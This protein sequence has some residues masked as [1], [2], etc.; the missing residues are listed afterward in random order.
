MGTRRTVNVE[1]HLQFLSSRWLK[2]GQVAGEFIGVEDIPHLG[3][4]TR[5]LSGELRA[6]IC[7]LSKIQQ[8]FAEKIIQRALDAELL[9]DPAGRPALMHPDLV[10]LHAG[11]YIAGESRTQITPGKTGGIR[12]IGCTPLNTYLFWNSLK[13]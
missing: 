2:G 11:N 4:K 5:K 10:E 1:K 6:L 3:L 12:Q 8:F 7:R 9:F 13:K